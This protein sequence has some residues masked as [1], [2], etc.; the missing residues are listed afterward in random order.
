MAHQRRSAGLTGR[1]FLSLRG[2]GSVRAL[3]RLRL[4]L[5]LRLRIRLRIPLRIRL[6]IRL[7]LRRVRRRAAFV[8][9]GACRA[10]RPH[11]LR[12]LRASSP[13]ARGTTSPGKQQRARSARASLQPP[14]AARK[15]GTQR[16]ASARSYDSSS[17]RH[18]CP[19]GHRDVAEFVRSPCGYQ[20]AIRLIGI[21]LTT[22]RRLPYCY[23]RFITFLD[24]SRRIDTPA[25]AL[26]ASGLHGS[27]VIV[28]RGRR[29]TGHLGFESH[30]GND[31]QI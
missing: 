9:T 19:A 29:N 25:A 12:P 13:L 5:R 8:R 11:P 4:R 20:K 24:R 15:A 1:A 30:E 17:R 18:T 22:R 23:A 31:L 2:R 7:R 6:R 3:A 27:L 16:A 21:L 14:G 10:V 28:G 26:A